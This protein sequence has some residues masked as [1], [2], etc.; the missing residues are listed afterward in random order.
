MW[1]IHDKLW[2]RANIFATDYNQA[3]IMEEKHFGKKQV[4]FQTLG[5]RVAM[6]RLI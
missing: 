4:S 1:V 2:L 6:L 3:K 5:G